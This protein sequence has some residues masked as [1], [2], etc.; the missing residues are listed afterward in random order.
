MVLDFAPGATSKINKL[1]VLGS[2]GLVGEGREKFDMTFL[3]GW[4]PGLGMLHAGPKQLKLYLRGMSMVLLGHMDI[5]YCWR[6]TGG[7]TAELQGKSTPLSRRQW[8][9]QPSAMASE[10]DGSLTRPT[11]TNHLNEKLLKPK[12]NDALP[13]SCWT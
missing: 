7:A 11:N 3:F 12:D 5:R 1:H 8:P 6:T 9:S 2:L 13:N 4:T 10:A